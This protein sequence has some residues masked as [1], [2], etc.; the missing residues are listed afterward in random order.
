[1]GRHGIERPLPRARAVRD[2]R[3]GA[4]AAT[5]TANLRG[6]VGGARTATPPR[7]RVP[8]RGS[9]RAR[10]RSRTRTPPGSGLAGFV[11]LATPAGRVAVEP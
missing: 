4:P 7:P 6:V 3:F 9:L 5:W 8:C 1:M 11:N 10:A 2:K